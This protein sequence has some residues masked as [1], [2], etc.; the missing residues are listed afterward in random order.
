MPEAKHY[1]SDLLDSCYLYTLDEKFTAGVK[2]SL[3]KGALEAYT[4]FLKNEYK[5]ITLTSEQRTMVTQ[6][7]NPQ[8]ALTAVAKYFEKEFH[9]GGNKA[10]NV[11]RLQTAGFVLDEDIVRHTISGETA[12]LDFQAA[13]MN[14]IDVT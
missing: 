2:M 3:G 1:N 9:T 11:I 12:T 4:I 10:E 7:R 14:E 5:S 13:V 6:T 8:A